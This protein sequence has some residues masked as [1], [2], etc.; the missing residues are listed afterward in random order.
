MIRDKRIEII[1]KIA[2]R[3]SVEPISGKKTRKE[4]EKHLVKT[5]GV[6]SQTAKSLES[7]L[8][9][10]SKL[11]TEAD[12]LKSLK[13]SA[14]SEIR[15]CHKVLNSMDLTD[16]DTVNIKKDGD[17]LYAKDGKWYDYA[18]DGLVARKRNKEEKEEDSASAEDGLDLDFEGAEVHL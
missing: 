11:T 9:Q 18:E 13:D 15:I 16:S 4:I 1:N 3:E 7:I 12:A 17:V 5:K 10:I 6:Y 8:G 2:K 14:V